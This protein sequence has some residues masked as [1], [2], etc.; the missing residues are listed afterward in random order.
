MTHITF[1]FIQYSNF[2]SILSQFRSL[3]IDRENW[4]RVFSLLSH[5]LSARLRKNAMLLQISLIRIVISDRHKRDA[6]RLD[7]CPFARKKGKIARCFVH[8]KRPCMRVFIPIYLARAFV[9][10]SFQLR[11]RLSL[12]K[13]DLAGDKTRRNTRGCA[14]RAN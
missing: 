14:I 8:V 5:V 10:D 13:A 3:I 6:L 7:A 12:S 11:R 4:K 9:D 2:S 1:E